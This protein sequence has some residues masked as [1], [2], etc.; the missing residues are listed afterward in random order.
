MEQNIISNYRIGMCCDDNADLSNAT[1]LY[2]GDTNLLTLDYG[3]NLQTHTNLHRFSNVE[4]DGTTTLSSVKQG[5][6]NYN[7]GT[8][9]NIANPNNPTDAVNK[10]YVD[11]SYNFISQ[12]VHQN[13]NWIN[14]LDTDLNNLSIKVHDLSNEVQQLEADLSGHNHDGDYLKLNG[15]GGQTVTN[16]F[17]MGEHA[18]IGWESTSGQTLAIN[19]EYD[20]TNNQSYL[21][22][23]KLLISS[24]DT[25][26][27]D[28]S[29]V[30]KHEIANMISNA[31]PETDPSLAHIDENETITGVYDFTNGMKTNTITASGNLHI[32]S[33]SGITLNEK[34]ISNVADPVYLYDVA[35]KNY[36]DNHSGGGSNVPTN[37]Q[38]AQGFLPQHYNI[39]YLQWVNFEGDGGSAPIGTGMPQNGLID[40]DVYLTFPWSGSWTSLVN[41]PH[42]GYI[43]PNTATSDKFKN[44]AWRLGIPCRDSNNQLFTQYYSFSMNNNYF[45]QESWTSSGWVNMIGFSV[46]DFV[47]PSN[48]DNSQ[49]ISVSYLLSVSRLELPVNGHYVSCVLK[50]LSNVFP[51]L[52]PH[53]NGLISITYPRSQRTQI[54]KTSWDAVSSSVSLIANEDYTETSQENNGNVYVGD[55]TF[56]RNVPESGLSIPLT[57]CNVEGYKAIN[58]EHLTLWKNYNNGNA[59]TMESTGQLEFVADISQSG[60]L[61]VDVY[62]PNTSTENVLIATTSSTDPTYSDTLQ[63]GVT[64][65]PSDGFSTVSIPITKL[66]NAYNSQTFNLS[67]Q[68]TSANTTLYFRNIVLRDVVPIVE[69]VDYGVFVENVSPHSISGTNYYLGGPL[70][71]RS[72]ANWE[73]D[74]F[75]A[76]KSGNY[77]IDVSVRGSGSE[78]N[79]TMYI[80][81]IVGNSVYRYFIAEGNHLFGN[82]SLDLEEGD[83][84]KVVVNA[85]STFTTTATTI[86]L[87]GEK[88]LSTYISITHNG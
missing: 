33:Q 51:S 74:V 16:G 23:E 69:P 34:T 65:V 50:G 4:L 56:N 61:D 6:V 7:S 8:I 11:D 72:N 13:T 2:D 64:I 24:Y 35:T 87:S 88:I 75:T 1:L 78:T 22:T 32:N 62:I 47:L 67:L 3:Q 19:T 31:I 84:I 85:F 28:N 58:A 36:V 18:E 63:N 52:N 26:D 44:M 37:V 41:R 40:I 66:N 14:E 12:K 15:D 68:N 86:G 70:Y 76:P 73:N 80:E 54:A 45:V 38:Y 10:Q 77:K 29:V 79:G 5:T 81:K 25:S 17:T 21:S 48:Y 55:W 71:T 57:D 39:P 43:Q 60:F 59:M 53:N 46:K 49:M 20:A 83:Q 42:P 27:P 30:P 82:M 9:T